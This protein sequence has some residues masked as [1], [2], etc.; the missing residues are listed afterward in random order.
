MFVLCPRTH[1]LQARNIRLMAAAAVRL[2]LMSLEL[3]MLLL[4]TT[5]TPNC[6][7]LL[8]TTVRA[9]GCM[10]TGA[11]LNQVQQ[12]TATSAVAAT[13]ELPLQEQCCSREQ[14]ATA[15]REGAHTGASRRKRWARHAAA[16]LDGARNGH[17]QFADAKAKQPARQHEAA[18]VAVAALNVSWRAAAASARRLTR[19]ACAGRQVGGQAAT[20]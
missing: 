12:T 17:L 19:C 5:P 7:L 3:L 10:S 2:L 6:M 14:R 15:Y 13:P 16:E 11:A 8:P 18:A 1:G 9:S 4:C 20:V